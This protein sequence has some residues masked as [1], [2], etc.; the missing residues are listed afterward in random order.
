MTS[1]LTQVATLVA[2]LA[3]C[4]TA[5][6]ITPRSPLKGVTIA[7]AFGIVAALLITAVRNFG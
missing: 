6:I 1:T 2:G 3:I 7:I 5:F 4:A